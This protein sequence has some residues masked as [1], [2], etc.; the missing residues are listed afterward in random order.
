MARAA[1]ETPTQGQTWRQDDGHLA[2][3]M[4]CAAVTRGRLSRA[5][6]K[7]PGT[8]SGGPD[9]ARGRLLRGAVFCT[10]VVAEA[11]NGVD[12]QERGLFG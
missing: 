1:T 5:G 11:G 4:T 10:Q 9:A 6:A 8:V 3:R 2:A 7:G 12:A